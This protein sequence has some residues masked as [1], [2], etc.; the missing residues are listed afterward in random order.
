ME[1]AWG[2]KKWPESTQQGRNMKSTQTCSTSMLIGIARASHRYV[3]APF[4]T[5]GVSE[6]GDMPISIRFFCTLVKATA[7]LS[8][9]NSELRERG[10]IVEKPRKIVRSLPIPRET[11][12]DMEKSSSAYG[13]T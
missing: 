12:A 2:A 11:K 10:E 3:T 4:P 1:T 8:A 9:R 13:A 6:V 7:Y 5:G